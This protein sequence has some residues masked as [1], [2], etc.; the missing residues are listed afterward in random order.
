MSLILFLLQHRWFD[1][2]EAATMR[3]TLRALQQ[4]APMCGV[5]ENVTGLGSHGPTE[6]ITNH[7]SNFGGLWVC[8]KAHYD[9]LEQLLPNQSREDRACC[10]N[11]SQDELSFLQ[12][13]AVKKEHCWES[14]CEPLQV[15][16][17]KTVPMNKPASIQWVE[18]LNTSL[19]AA[20]LALATCLEQA[21]TL[22]ARA[23]LKES[24]Q[25]GLARFPAWH[26]PRTS[27]VAPYQSSHTVKDCPKLAL[28]KITSGMTVQMQG[29]FLAR[30]HSE[31]LPSLGFMKKRLSFPSGGSGPTTLR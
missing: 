26:L 18:H 19:I 29:V 3:L 8:H 5:L 23:G 1:H 6:P 11:L 4:R 17:T 21:W 16:L 27:V 12:I 14:W 22:Q 28:P 13:P 24:R 30:G 31:N 10:C 25:I 20:M 9:L 7:H 15:L 2:E